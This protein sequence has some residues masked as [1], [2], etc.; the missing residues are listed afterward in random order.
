MVP[1]LPSGVHT[2]VPVGVLTI[3]KL[4]LHVFDKPINSVKTNAS[5]V[6]RFI[7]FPFPP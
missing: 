6:I 5:N 7:L 4:A 2:V 1:L 3:I